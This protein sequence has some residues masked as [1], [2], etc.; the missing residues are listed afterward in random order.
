MKPS[1]KPSATLRNRLRGSGVSLDD[2]LK[3]A[4]IAHVEAQRLNIDHQLSQG[5]IRTERLKAWASI[6]G[7]LTAIVGLCALLWSI[8]Q[9]ILQ[10]RLQEADRLDSQ[11]QTTLAGI[12]DERVS[13]RLA[14]AATL[15]FVLQKSEQRRVEFLTGAGSL[16]ATE[17][18]P[19]VRSAILRLYSTLISIETPEQALSGA[20]SSLAEASRSLV[21]S[22][23]LREKHAWLYGSINDDTV[24]SRAQSV[25]RA[26]V[27]LLRRGARSEN[28]TEIYCAHCDFSGLSLP[29]VDLS[30][31]IVAFANFAKADLSGA[32]LDG[33]DMEGT[34]FERARLVGAS[35]RY[36]SWRGIDGDS[37]AERRL[38][39]NLGS[40]SGP[41]FA[42]ADL[43][44]ADFD[45]QPIL[46]L[47][48][49]RM[50]LA[51]SNLF[52]ARFTGAIVDGTDFSGA[53]FLHIVPRGTVD[54]LDAT[55]VLGTD[56]VH[57]RPSDG[58]SDRVGEFAHTRLAAKPTAR[59]SNIHR[60]PQYYIYRYAAAVHN[61]ALFAGAARFRRLAAPGTV[62]KTAPLGEDYDLAIQNFNISIFGDFSRAK[63]A[64][65]MMNFRSVHPLPPNQV[66]A[67]RC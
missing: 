63:L 27:L 11:I 39:R 62:I 32:R 8:W 64:P 30:H 21:I 2:Q 51:H 29:K 66:G 52:P 59:G 31:A 26:I 23:E 37:Y 60:A 1:Q 49:R 61:G 16:L 22:G 53:S 67:S 14:A 55:P 43:S 9:G 35:V 10:L 33:A 36:G 47:A 24:E 54:D 34:S 19:I 4:Q 50:N 17:R 3:A 12:T 48:A 58:S 57:V 65:W 20:L 44:R 7:G 45:G 28:L 18:D 56:P 42:C 25:A 5:S 13:R 40:F 15:A 41:S 46:F 38:A 6:L